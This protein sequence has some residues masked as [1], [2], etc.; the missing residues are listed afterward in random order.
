MS[1]LLDIWHSIVGL[2]TTGD[3]IALVIMAVI[4]LA[5]GVA[6]ENMGSIVTATFSALVLFA[7]ATFFREVAKTGGRNANELAQADW[8]TFLGLT[9]HS[10]LAYAITFAIAIG[11]VHVVRQVAQR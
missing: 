10:L 1:A 9:V 8:H 11:V 3:Y 2:I 6:M 7:V 5:I 4:A